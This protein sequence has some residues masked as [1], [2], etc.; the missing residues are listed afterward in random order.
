MLSRLPGLWLRRIFHCSP[1]RDNGFPHLPSAYNSLKTSWYFN[2]FTRWQIPQPK[3]AI[4]D[5]KSRCG[6]LSTPT[7]YA[8][9]NEIICN[10]AICF[11]REWNRV[12]IR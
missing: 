6:F 11:I 10:F 5:L 4:R 1:E 12:R 3:I 9:Y 8:K 2:F 7:E